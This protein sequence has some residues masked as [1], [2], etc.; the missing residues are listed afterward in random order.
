MRTHVLFSFA[1]A[2]SLMAAEPTEKFIPDISLI[3]DFGYL[4][5][6]LDAHQM[7]LL[8]MPGFTHAAAEEAEHG[9]DHGGAAEG[10]NLNYAELV[11]AAAVDHRFDLLTAFHLSEDSFEVEEAY[12][13]TRG[14]GGGLDMKAGKFLSGIGRINPHHPHAWSFDAQPLIYNAFLGEHGLLEKG[15]QM[16]WLA[17]SETY[18][19]LGVEVLQG[20]NEMSFGSETFTILPEDGNTSVGV[21]SGEVTA[22]ALA[23]AFIKTSVDTG[24][25][26]TLVGLSYLSGASRINH[27]DHG[28]DG[29]ATIIAADLTLK[30]FLNSYSQLTWQ[31]EYMQ[32]RMEGTQLVQ[33]AS[34]V[35]QANLEKEQAGYYTQLVYRMD[36]SWQAG[37]RYDA[38]TQN[39]VTVNGAD[40]NKPEALTRTTLNL[41]YNPSHFSRLRISYTQDDSQYE[42]DEKRSFQSL[43]VSF[44]MA[45]GTH[46]AHSF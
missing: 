39:S 10:F 6:S 23:T 37:V 5:N 24:D 27:E 28:F 8:E 20:E 46:G 19:L 35:T 17:P 4:H 12:I 21:E 45:I 43:S 42:E 36:K 38:I 2:A 13:R 30:Y 44:N 41:D 18:L 11:M 33:G 22:P 15:V 40:Q 1:A 14:L 3:T 9:H 7:E 32:R 29:T 26:T 31:S 34:S 25:L 16:T